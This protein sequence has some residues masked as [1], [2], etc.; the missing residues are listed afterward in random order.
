M[1]LSEGNGTSKR[2]LIKVLIPRKISLNRL[3]VVPASRVESHVVKLEELGRAILP[4]PFG[5]GA[6]SIQ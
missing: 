2:L 6:V 4:L 3:V 5:G 1:K